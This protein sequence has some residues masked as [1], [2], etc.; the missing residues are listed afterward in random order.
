MN[1]TSKKKMK[2]ND[3]FFYSWKINKKKMKNYNKIILKIEFE[4]HSA[5]K[6]RR[7]LFNKDEILY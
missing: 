2:R 6:T 1:Q 7:K 5:I 3:L 4:K